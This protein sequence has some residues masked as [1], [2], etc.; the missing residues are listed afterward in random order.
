M[1]FERHHGHNRSLRQVEL[2]VCQAAQAGVN[3]RARLHDVPTNASTTL[4]WLP[5][6]GRR[7]TCGRFFQ[8][9]DF[10]THSAAPDNALAHGR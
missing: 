9:I 2:F 4:P 6:C 10:N 7:S 8:T 3:C 1:Q 5:C